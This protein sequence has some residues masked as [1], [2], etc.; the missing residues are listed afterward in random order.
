MTMA[1]MMKTKTK[2][3]IDSGRMVTTTKKKE[4][5][6]YPSSFHTN[7]NKGKHSSYWD[8]KIDSIDDDTDDDNNGERSHVWVMSSM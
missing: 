3:D 6:I 1:L 7:P 2:V 4:L 8:S 5:E